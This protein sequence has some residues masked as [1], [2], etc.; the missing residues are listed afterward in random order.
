MSATNP[1][2]WWGT[3]DFEEG[4]RGL[5]SVGP[6]RLSVLRTHGEWRIEYVS[7]DDG[8]PSVATVEYPTEVRLAGD[9]VGRSRFSFDKTSPSLHVTPVLAD[10]PAIISPEEAFHVTGGQ[11]ITLFCSTP[12]WIRLATGEE[13]IALMEIPTFRPPDTWFGPSTQS[14]E[15][16]YATRTA[17]RLRREDLPIRPHRAVTALHIHNKVDHTL[18][19]DRINLSVPHLSL[20]VAHDAS[21][22]TDDVTLTRTSIGAHG[23]LTVDGPPPGRGV[24]PVS[25]SREPLKDTNIVVRAFSALFD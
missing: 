23:E 21:F 11:Q 6:L 10:R 15:L 16:C 14:G 9:D 8:T 7:H 1:S 25:K 2:E 20:Y 17:A 12:L 3:F 22:W 13:Q 4:T 24:K 5:W 19:V 18:R